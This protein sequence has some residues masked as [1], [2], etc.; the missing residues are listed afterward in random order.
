MELYP[1]V[2]VQG[3]RVARAPA[4]LADPLA[5]LERYQRAGA[6]WVH[7][8][9]LDRVYGRGANDELTRAC[10]AGAGASMRVQV[11]GR[12]GTAADRKSVV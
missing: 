4:A 9:D 6:R 11:G 5:A 10:V 7:L 2:D 8:V 3:G 1:A 12:V